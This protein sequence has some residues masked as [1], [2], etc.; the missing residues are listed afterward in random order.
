MK[1]TIVSILMLTLVAGLAF[2]AGDK[3]P[4]DVDVTMQ[5]TSRIQITGSFTE[6]SPVWDR[7]YGYDVPAPESC[8]YPLTAAYYTGQY[9]DMHCINASNTDPVEIAVDEATTLDDTTLH[10]FCEA[11]DPAMPL[12]NCVFFD[13]DDGPGLFSAITVDDNVVLSPGVNYWLVVS[14]YGSGDPGDMGDFV[15]NT[16]DN[17]VLCGGVANEATDWSS[18]KALFD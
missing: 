13:D 11:F 6:S 12:D 16:S 18:I 15:I 5:M 7:G 4:D 1:I 2:A 3:R 8:D 10:I 14:N 9:Y 17:V